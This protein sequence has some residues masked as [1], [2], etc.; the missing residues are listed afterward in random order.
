MSLSG[1]DCCIFSPRFSH[2]NPSYPSI[3]SGRCRPRLSVRTCER[4]AMMAS[5]LQKVYISKE[6]VAKEYTRRCKKGAWKKENTEEALKCW[7]LERIIDADLMGEDKPSQLTMN[8]LVS[9]GIETASVAARASSTTKQVQEVV[10][11][12]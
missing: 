6:W 1:R 12:V 9:E 2:E 10:E 3:S 5:I 7:N 4:L 8:D 11:V